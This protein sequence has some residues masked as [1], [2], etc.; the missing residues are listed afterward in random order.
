MFLCALHR[1]QLRASHT[2]KRLCRNFYWRRNLELAYLNERLEGTPQITLLNGP[3]QSGKSA[4]VR[5]LIRDRG[6]NINALILNLR[7][8]D[9]NTPGRLYET[10]LAKFPTFVREGCGLETPA[11]AGRYLENDARLSGR[12][13]SIEPILKRV[14]TLL[15]IWER[16]REKKLP[17][18]LIV[19]DHA[20]LLMNFADTSEGAITLRTVIPL[21]HRLSRTTLNASGYSFWT[22]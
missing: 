9:Y 1:P 13:R 15:P 14:S 10:L 11:L 5:E 20:S 16:R 7:Q 2:L 12:L 8:G 22:G 6:V 19:V 4:L 21:L 3:P 17:V 18:S